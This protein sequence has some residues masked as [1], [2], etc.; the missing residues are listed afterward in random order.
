MT[1]SKDDILKEIAAAKL[2]AHYAR[3]PEIRTEAL[4]QAEVCALALRGLEVEADLSGVD[5]SDDEHC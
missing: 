5:G 1:I 4:R 2:E 3:T